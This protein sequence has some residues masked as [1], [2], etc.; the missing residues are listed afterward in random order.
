MPTWQKPS[1]TRRGAEKKPMQFSLDGKAALVTGSSRG[2]GSE[3]ARGLAEAGARVLTHG[4]EAGS[5]EI[6]GGA[7]RQADLADPDAPRALMEAAF[8]REP[9]LSILVSNAGSFFDIPFLEMTPERWE[10]T[11]GLNLRAAYFL[12]QAF[13]RRLV[14]EK[15]GGAVVVTASTNGLQAE[16][17]SSAYDISK[18]GLVMLTRSLALDL[19]EHDIRVN[20]IAPG[21][22]R[23]P[24]TDPWLQTRHAQRELYEKAIP[25]GRVGTPEDCVGATVFL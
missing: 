23:T 24:L 9:G 16:R 4:H 1:Q 17:G 18:G 13:V 7:Y 21:L 5:P 12:I 15:R 6:A 11:I 25:A 20:A 3:I 2:I 19:A 8:D 14:Q 22:I 10:R